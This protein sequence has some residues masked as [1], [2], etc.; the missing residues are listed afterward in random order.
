MLLVRALD[1]RAAVRRAGRGRASTYAEKITAADRTL[2]PAAPAAARE[3]VVRALHAAHR[4]AHAR[5]M[6]A[7]SSA[8]SRR[9]SRTASSCRSR[10]CHPAGGAM[11]Y[12]D[13]LP[14]PRRPMSAG[15]ARQ[16]GAA[17]GAR[18]RP[19][20]ARRAA[21]TPT[22]R[23]TARRRAW[24]RATARSPS[25]WRS[26]PSSA[27]AR[28]TGSST[29]TRRA[30]LEPKVRAALHLGLEQLLFL[31]GIAD[32][33]RDRRVGRARQ[34]EP[35]AQRRQRRAAARP[36]RGRRAA[37]RRHARGARAIRH[38]HPLWLVELWWDWLGPERT[39]AL[40]EADNEPAELALR[41]NPLAGAPSTLER[42]PGAARGRDDRRRRRR[43]TCSPT[44]AT[45]AGAFTPQSRAAQRVARFVG[46]AARRARARPVCRARAARRRIWPR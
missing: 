14:R 39:R 44:P 41:V 7:R 15:R 4:C 45:R 43:S 42:H 18:R 26:A 21:P 25:A 10:C 30:A 23:S 20:H 37:R 17:R 8:S 12:A 24:S 33:R 27:A 31:D 32:A 36:A 16:P 38:A 40:L 22:A 29:A 19:A 5:S 11:A 3:R 46:P 35:R 13:Y 2:D 34:A 6:T 28:S 1:E 9:A